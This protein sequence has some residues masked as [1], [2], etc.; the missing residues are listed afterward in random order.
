[1]YVV[2]RLATYNLVLMNDKTDHTG[3]PALLASGKLWRKKNTKT[4]PSRPLLPGTVIVRTRKKD[5][6]CMWFGS[7]TLSVHGCSNK[8]MPQRVDGVKGV[9][10]CN[11]SAM[12]SMPRGA[13][14]KSHSERQR[15]AA[16]G[17]QGPVAANAG[18]DA[19][20]LQLRSREAAVRCTNRHSV[21]SAEAQSCRESGCGTGHCSRGTEP[22]NRSLHLTVV[23]MPQRL[24]E[25][26]HQAPDMATC[27]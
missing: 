9:S 4:T 3:G 11:T 10:V 22:S 18:P 13:T 16:P 17:S 1:V 7:K 24:F 27:T 26:M 12:C 2:W 25:K 15:N 14:H 20:P 8:Y 19:T 21:Q 5:S 23:L 6:W